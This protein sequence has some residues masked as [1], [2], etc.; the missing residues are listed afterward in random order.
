M[1]SL[2]DLPALAQSFPGAEVSADG[3]AISLTIK[4][5]KKGICWVWMERT[6]PK[7][8]RVPNLEV[9]AV[10]TPNLSAKDMLIATEPGKFFTEPHYNGFS[11]VLVRLNAVSFSE[12]ED[13]LLEA[14]RAKA[15]KE[16]LAQLSE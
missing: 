11:A 15:T 3:R 10:V 8:A 6:D 14:Y 1:A 5:K 13:L 7:K 16:M 12:L 9:L 4:G 2:S